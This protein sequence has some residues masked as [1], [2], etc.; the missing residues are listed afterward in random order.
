MRAVFEAVAHRSPY[1]REQFS[2]NR[3]NHMVL[4]ALFVD[5]TLHPMQG[6]EERANPELAKM[7]CDYAHERWAAGRPSGRAAS[8]A[9][10]RGRACGAP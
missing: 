6:L 4:K 8:A 2:E 5:S 10:T 1:P 7:L 3:W 9:C